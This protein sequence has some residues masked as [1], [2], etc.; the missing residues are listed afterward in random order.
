MVEKPDAGQL[1]TSRSGDVSEE[2]DDVIHVLCLQAQAKKIRVVNK[3]DED[4]TVWADKNMINLVLRNLVSNAIKFSPIGG[5]ITV[6]A[7][8]QFDFAEIYV[9][10]NG[11]GI[12][13]EEIKKI[14]AQEF[15]SNKWHRSRTRYRPRPDAL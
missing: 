8:E 4:V 2:V 9:Q 11:K 12:S 7:Q 10:D 5:T 3:S 6:G 1:G 15:Y 13:Q 14:E